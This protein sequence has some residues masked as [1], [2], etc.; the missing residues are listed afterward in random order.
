MSIGNDVFIVTKNGLLSCGNFRQGTAQFAATSYEAVNP[1][2][3][4][5]VAKITQSN[6]DYLESRSFKYDNE[7]LAG[8]KIGFHSVLAS[9]FTTTLNSWTIFSGNFKEAT[10]FCVTNN[11]L[12][13]SIN[14]ILYK[15][16]DGKDGSLAL[17]GDDNDKSPVFFSWVLPIMKVEK[18]AYANYFY[19][20]TL[21]YSS[22]FTLRKNNQITLQVSGDVPKS[23]SIDSKYRFE[24][25]GDAFSTVPFS[26]KAYNQVVEGDLGF[27]SAQKY[28]VIK[29]KFKFVAN[30]FWLIVSGQT[31]DGVLSFKGVNLYGTLQ[32]KR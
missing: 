13:L 26:P 20:I 32:R 9:L 8:F 1:L 14:N 10:A 12:Y 30:R 3:L 18:M 21:S 23:Y 28:Q 16:A 5:Y 25:M 15:Y 17:Y 24:I 27:Y 4:Q 7:G 19:D 2:I 11:A 6:I 22:N 31:R 29:E